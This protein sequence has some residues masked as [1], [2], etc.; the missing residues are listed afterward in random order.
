MSDPEQELPVPREEVEALV[1][2]HKELPE[3]H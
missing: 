1:E 2:A 3:G